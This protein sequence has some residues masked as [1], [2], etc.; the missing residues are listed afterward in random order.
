MWLKEKE[1]NI[2]TTF[3]INEGIPVEYS[4]SKKKKLNTANAQG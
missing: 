4:K 3:E 1:K 2:V